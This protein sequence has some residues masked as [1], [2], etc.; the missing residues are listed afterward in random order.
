MLNHGNNLLSMVNATIPFFLYLLCSQRFRSMTFT[1]IQS[2]FSQKKCCQATVVE[3]KI[4]KSEIID[5]DLYVGLM[6]VKNCKDSF[7]LNLL[8]KSRSLT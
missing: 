2:K 1:Y 4:V 5:A 6:P 3:Q 7:D 8:R